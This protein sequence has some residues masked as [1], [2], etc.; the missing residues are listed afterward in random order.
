MYGA[1]VLD[2]T[3]FHGFCF[4]S[5]EQ[6]MGWRSFLNVARQIGELYCFR[7]VIVQAPGRVSHAKA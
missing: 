1:F 6:S 3:R 4:D 2:E 5:A 7:N